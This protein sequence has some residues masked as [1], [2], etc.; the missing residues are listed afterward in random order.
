M[1][2]FSTE[3]IKREDHIGGMRE[4]VSAFNYD[5]VENHIEFIL[6]GFFDNKSLTDACGNDAPRFYNVQDRM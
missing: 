4:I 5:G 2:K 3:S 6:G 1:Q